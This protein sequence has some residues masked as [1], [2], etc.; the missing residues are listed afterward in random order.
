MGDGKIDLHILNGDYAAKLLRK[1]IDSGEALVWRETYL[2]GP[3]PEVEDL[4]LFRKA[5]AE[6]L[7]GFAEISHIGY[8]A[9]YKHLKSLEDAVLELPENSLCFNTHKAKAVRS[10]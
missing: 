4:H 3:L 7:S 8:D 2:E 6:F 10:G 1:C 9:L 5:R